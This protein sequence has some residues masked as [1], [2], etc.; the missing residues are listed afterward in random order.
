VALNDLLLDLLLLRL[1]RYLNL[2]RR[3]QARRIRRKNVLTFDT[4]AARIQALTLLYCTS[5]EIN[6][7]KYEQIKT[8]TGIGQRS[9]QF[10]AAKAKSRGFNPDISLRVEEKHVEDAP[11]AGAPK[12]ATN[13][14][15]Q[16]K[17]LKLVSK[18]RATREYSAQ[19]IGYKTKISETSVLRIMKMNRVRKC[20]RTSK[21]GLT[22]DMREARLQFA[23][24]YKDWTIEQWKAVI[25]SDETSVV[26]G[27]RR[28]A[29]R[30][31]RMPSEVYHPDVLRRR[32]KGFSDFMFWGCF[33]YD[34]KGPCHIWRK[35]TDAE[36]LAAQKEI[37]QWNSDNEAR[38]KEE[39]EI[40]N[41][42][43]RTNLQRNPGGRKPK[44]N[45]T[46]ETGKRVRKAKAGGIDWYRY[47]KEILKAK[48]LPFA[49]ECLKHNPDTIVQE[50]KA[51]AH[52]HKSQ[53]GIFNF[54]KVQRLL[55]PGNSPDL[56]MIEPCWPWM[57]RRTTSRGAPSCS[58][59]MK[60]S[61]LKAWKELPQTKIQAWIERIPRH[62]QEIIR[63]E[64]GNEY[65]EGR[66][67]KDSRKRKG[68]R[69]KG[70]LEE[71]VDL[72]DGPLL[73]QA[74]L[75]MENNDEVEIPTAEETLER[76]YE[77]VFLNEGDEDES[78]DEGPSFV[79]ESTVDTEGSSAISNSSDDNSTIAGNPATPLWNYR[80]SLFQP[81][82]RPSRLPLSIKSRRHRRPATPERPNA[83]RNSP[84][85]LT[86]L[87]GSSRY[88]QLPPP[89]LPPPETPS[90][91][92]PQGTAAPASPGA[93]I[94]SRIPAPRRQISQERQA[95]VQCPREAPALAIE[96]TRSQY[97][98]LRC[99]RVIWEAKVG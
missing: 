98:R 79:S 14:E 73:T 49:K 99:P 13:E 21:P 72:G 62:I 85:D 80:D 71:R 58:Y 56:N 23:L 16:E 26:L 40:A 12:T 95:E 87:F 36:K 84:Q 41:D 61:W 54:W 1:N 96:G 90:R 20:K 37:D 93:S 3:P 25:W 77:G 34:R 27:Q 35:E 5:G 97:G 47:G 64:G 8:I 94:L 6:S 17:V 67:G 76:E 51:P 82:P 33:S 69:K 9:L 15:M 50:D 38:L 89:P 28:G 30:V 59:L 44:W 60:R 29:Q 65:K 18:D 46:E 88:L 39:W 45:F 70:M 19:Y 2:S 83:P 91:I 86:E 7:A 31:W 74:E 68:K 63:L 55:W 4:N 66:T 22:D 53:S 92:P 57:K 81:S 43:R 10:L 75:E 42:L 52:V 32:W 11:R 78:V 48:L 24:R